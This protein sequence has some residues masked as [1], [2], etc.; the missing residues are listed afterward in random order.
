VLS[1]SL[2]PEVSLSSI[3][4]SDAD[5]IAAVL[6]TWFFVVLPSKSTD[7]TIG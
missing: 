5:A 6:R 2:E 3:D 4:T 7:F 1:L